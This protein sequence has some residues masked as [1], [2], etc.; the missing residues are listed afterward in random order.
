MVAGK[1]RKEVTS[2]VLWLM[3]Y[4]IRAQCFKVT[5]F[6]LD[7][8]LF[9]NIEQ[10]LPVKDT[11]DYSIRMANKAKEEIKT[12]DNLKNR[13]NIRL[14]F[15][16]K[17]LE[18]SNRVNDLYVN[19]SPTND[20]WLRKSMGM[21]GL[22]LNIIVTGEY[23]QSDIAVNRGDKEENKK[24]FDFLYKMKDKIETAFGGELIW[25]R[26]DDKVTCR[27]KSVLTD[28]D[29]FDKDDWSKMIKFLVDASERMYNA[30]KNPIKKLSEF[31]KGL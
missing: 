29:V 31:S 17:Y 19:S 13:H 2:T 21:F 25:D 27:I 28:V 10:I 12:Q 3:N 11:E 20:R 22:S 14:E 30:F 16:K 23:A 5:P 7:E 4:N 1:F 9:L 24:C 26:Q 15:W 18:A 6:A 8:K